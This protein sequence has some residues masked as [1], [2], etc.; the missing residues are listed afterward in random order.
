[1]ALDADKFKDFPGVS[2]GVKSEPSGDIAII[3]TF[4]FITKKPEEECPNL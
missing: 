3:K 1:M 2:N 4:K